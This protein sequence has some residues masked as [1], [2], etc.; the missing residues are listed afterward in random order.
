MTNKQRIGALRHRI[1]IQ[2]YTEVPFGLAETSKT[3][4]T[5]TTRWGNVE[6]LKGLVYFDTQQIGKGVTHMITIRYDKQL[7]V[8]TE[9]WILFRG[10]RYRIRSVRNPLE[11]RRYLEMLCE[12]EFQAIDNFEVSADTVSDPLREMLTE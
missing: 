11:N 1:D 3:W 7:A 8:T 5:L 9:N 2:Q 12:V 6:P 10:V 4:T